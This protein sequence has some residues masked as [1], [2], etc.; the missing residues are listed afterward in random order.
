MMKKLLLFLPVS[1][2]YVLLLPAQFRYHVESNPSA[3]SA[4]WMIRFEEGQRISG[5][6]INLLLQE[7]FPTESEWKVQQAYT[8]PT[9]MRHHRVNQWIQGFPVLGAQMV[10]HEMNGEL[11]SVNGHLAAIE[12]GNFKPVLSREAAVSRALQFLNVPVSLRNDISDHDVAEDRLVLI[13]RDYPLSGGTY[14]LAWELHVHLDQPHLSRRIYVDAENGNVLLD[15]NTLMNCAGEPGVMHTLF[16]GVQNVETEKEGNQYVTRD[17]SRGGGIQVQGVSGAVYTD[18]DNVW[19]AGSADQKNGAYDLFWGLQATH[20]FFENRF[21]R[22]GT[23]GAGLVTKAILLD[24]GRYSNAFWDGNL[25]TLNFGLGNGATVLPFTSV[26]IVGHEFAHG[27]TQFTAGLEYLYES[28]ALNEAF[29]DIFGKAI[30]YYY[31]QSNFN[32]LIGGKIFTNPGSAI[33]S[34]EDPNRFSNPKYYRG[35]SWV[36]SS[37]D[38]GGV[39]SNSGVLNYWYYLLCSGGKG[40][41]EGNQSFDVRPMGFDSATLIAYHLLRDFLTPTSTYQD[42]RNLCMQMIGQWWGLCSDPYKNVAEAWK[43]VGLGTG[44]NEND[45]QLVTDRVLYTVCKDGSVDLPTRLINHS[46]T[47]SIPAGT[48]FVASYQQD[49]LTPVS[50]EFILDRELAPGEYFL[51]RFS[52]RPLITRAGGVRFTVRMEGISDSDTTNNRYTFLLTRNPNATEHD[53]NIIRLTV[54]GSACPSSQDGYRASLVAAY[55]G[56][57][58][59]PPGSKLKM[60]M[61]FDDSLAVYEFTTNRS[62]YPGLQ[63]RPSAFVIPRAFYGVKRVEARL[64]WPLDTLL[65]NNQTGFQVV[66]A[67]YTYRDEPEQFADGNFNREK[68]QIYSDSFGFHQI[69]GPGTARAGNLLISGSS[70][71]DPNGE[72]RIRLNPDPA[73]FM[74][75]NSRYITSVFLCANTSGMTDPLIE[76]DLTQK[77]GDLDYLSLG[78]DPS[79]AVVSRL[80]FR[81]AEGQTT[82]VEYIRNGN[83]QPNLQKISLPIPDGTELVEIQTLAITGVLDPMGFPDEDKSDLALIDNIA[84]RE[85]VTSTREQTGSGWF[86]LSPQPF[87]D[88]LVLRFSEPMDSGLQFQIFDLGGKAV[89]SMSFLPGMAEIQIETGALLPGLYLARWIS[90]EGR[91][92][93]IR[94]LK[95]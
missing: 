1:L 85:S 95:L 11:V 20:D 15:I 74:N 28:G 79:F 44:P 13:N 81:N 38:N 4:Q 19:E 14:S 77:L 86:S 94:I 25:R 75:D 29:S 49:N 18:D 35:R 57:T 88:L 36:A 72:L 54:T 71:Y 17:L 34:M 63:L 7:I 2:F 6:D 73:G 59:V 23:N 90:Q 66:F 39:H 51:F 5:S 55:N 41:N 78:I 30:E 70:A 67:D 56:C 9:G 43:A 58:V 93:E 83:R 89:R 31:D 91:T 61:K 24:T 40:V 76:F 84:I 92:G 3:G 22:T 48:R 65:N 64:V 37:S 69:P 42:A 27:V 26:D 33:R 62:L 47:V 46:C 53:F 16:H 80:I 52:T 12:D 32:W 68:I 8:D 50:E 82:G 10:L 21:G 87:S 60:E 45:L